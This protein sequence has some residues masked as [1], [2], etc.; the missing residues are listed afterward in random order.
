MAAPRVA[1]RE[2]DFYRIHG[3]EELR[4]GYKGIPE[5]SAD[6]PKAET[7]ESVILVP[8]AV[9]TGGDTE[10]DTEAVTTTGIW[11]FIRM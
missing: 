2:M 1:G 9:F 4:A 10:L 5:P 8:V 3:K 7:G 11:R 6:C